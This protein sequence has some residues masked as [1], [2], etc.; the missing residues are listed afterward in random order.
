MN[1]ASA[2]LIVA[3]LIVL[4]RHLPV[5]AALEAAL[6]W[7]DRLGA[8]GPIAM[9][10]IYVACAVA[11][12][13]ATM[14]T[15]TCGALFG[16]GVGLAVASLGST[17][18]AAVAFLIARYLARDALAERLRHRPRF[19]ALDHAISAS[20]WKIVALMRLSPAVPYNAQNYLYGLTGLRFWPYALTTWAAMLPGTFVSV[21]IGHLGRM[22]LEEA[23]DLRERTPLE[24]A[25]VGLGLAATIAVTAYVTR[26]VR[27]A[28]TQADALELE[29][30]E[31]EPVPAPSGWPW[32]ATFAA[33]AALVLAVLAAWVTADPEAVAGLFARRAGA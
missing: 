20:G 33:L 17:I 3:S 32:A 18:G 22:S 11:M 29:S 23:A 1:W 16:L 5:A 25:A 7:V 4:A 15:I 12:V 26:L 6:G 10:A 8:W 13:P 21:Y 19:R 28:M 30:V 31:R 24:W 14:L 27:R 2:A 9:V